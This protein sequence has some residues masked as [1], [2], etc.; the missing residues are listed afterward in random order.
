LLIASAR[1]V[2]CAKLSSIHPSGGSVNGLSLF[3]VL[4]GCVEDLSAGVLGGGVRS[5]AIF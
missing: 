5:N 3:S 4:D 1:C 2:S